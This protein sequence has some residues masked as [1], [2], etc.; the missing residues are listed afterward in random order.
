VKI[1]V[2]VVEASSLAD[3]L[4]RYYRQDRLRNHDDAYGKGTLLAC[5]QK[6]LDEKGY[7]C[8]SHHDNT[9]GTFIYWPHNPNEQK[10]AKKRQTISPKDFL[11][12]S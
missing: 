4:N 6:D 8:T 5:Y 11:S 1:Q 9:T 3:Y 7:V 10:S 12:A 2:Q